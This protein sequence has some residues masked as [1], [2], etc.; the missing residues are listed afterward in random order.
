[1]VLEGLG[2][3]RAVH[4]KGGGAGHRTREWFMADIPSEE[5]K[6]DPAYP[7]LLFWSPLSL[8]FVGPGGLLS[9]QEA[10]KT[11]GDV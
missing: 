8:L 5:P 3:L 10:Q 1:M 2:A 4:R 6:R 7:V 9:G 11:P